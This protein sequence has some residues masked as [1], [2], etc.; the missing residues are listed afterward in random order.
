[1]LRRIQ[2]LLLQR[3]HDEG[4]IGQCLQSRTGFG[5]QD[6]D[7]MCHICGS[8]NRCC[9][10][11]IYVADELCFHLE[12]SGLLRPVLQGNVHGARA[13]IASAD[14]D[15]YRRGELLTLLICDF[16]RMYLVREICDSLLLLHIESSLVDTVR[17]NSISELSSRQMMEN[18][19]LLSCIDYLSVIEG[20][21]LFRELCLIR[22]LYKGIQYAAVHSLRRVIIGKAFR[23]RNAVA[24]HTLRSAFTGHNLCEVHLFYL[25]QL[26]IR[27]KLIKILP[28]DH[29]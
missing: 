26:P 18:Q 3:V 8:Q 14:T 5:Y 2:A 4:L 9:V 16:S 13:K 12:V 23:H 29:F 1:M 10:I 20:F 22:Q 17:C 6:E 15:L 7:R 27:S 19:S 24:L 28:V 25:L 11:R 21:I